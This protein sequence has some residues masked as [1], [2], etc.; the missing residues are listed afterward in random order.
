MTEIVKPLADRAAA[1]LKKL[2]YKNVEVKAGDGYKGWPEK[3]PF[4]A[5]IVTC[6]PEHI[7]QPLVDQLAEGGRMMIP[8]GKI[9]SVQ[10]L[11]LLEKVD[12]EIVEKAVLKVRLPSKPIKHTLLSALK[13]F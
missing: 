3:A 6:A 10:E 13:T 5:I 2:D 8:V 12:G 11:Y 1:V 4:D 9:R 7:P